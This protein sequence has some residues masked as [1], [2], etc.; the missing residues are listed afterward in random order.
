MSHGSDFKSDL[1]AVPVAGCLCSAGGQWL[2]DV[3][4]AD[5]RDVHRIGDKLVAVFRADTLHLA[6]HRGLF[7]GWR[8][9]GWHRHVRL[10]YGLL[11]HG[12]HCAGCRRG[13]CISDRHCHPF[14]FPGS[15]S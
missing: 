9:S 1:G 12:R 13:P 8:L 10:Q 5:D 3:D 4:R 14:V 15:I 11:A 6:G 2:L 7:R